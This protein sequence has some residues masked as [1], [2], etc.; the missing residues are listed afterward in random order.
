VRYT[1]WEELPCEVHLMG[2]A[3]MW[4]QAAV[5]GAGPHLRLFYRWITLCGIRLSQCLI[6]MIHYEISN[7]DQKLSH[8][9]YIVTHSY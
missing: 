6:I 9:Y 2:G 4:C 8:S 5:H 7:T 3:T 1:W